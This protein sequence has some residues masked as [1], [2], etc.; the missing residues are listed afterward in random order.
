MAFKMK[1][2]NFPGKSPA[3]QTKGSGKSSLGYLQKK[4]IK[5][6]IKKDKKDDN[7]RLH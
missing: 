7:V 2:F 1:G 6:N 4:N 5:K 3:K